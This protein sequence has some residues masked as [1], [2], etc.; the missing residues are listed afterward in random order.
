[1]AGK[2]REIQLQTVINSQ[3]LWDEML[4]NK[5]LTV[6]DVYQA[7]CGPCKA[8]Q[9]LFR[10][11]KNELNEDEILHFVV[12]EADSVA[13]LQPFRDNCEPIF[14]FSVNGKIVSKIEGANAP[15]VNKTIINLVNDEKKIAAGEIVRPQYHEIGLVGS[16]A[17]VGRSAS[18]DT[19]DRIYSIAIIKPEARN[20]GKTM[21][22]KENIVNAGFVIEAEDNRV[23][24][25]NQVREF[26][27]QIAEQ[28]DF[29]E[30][31]SLM[32]HSLSCVLVVSRSS[33][34]VP[35]LEE[36]IISKSETEPQE[37]PEGQPEM[38]PSSLVKKKWDSLEEYLVK[39]NMHQFCDV[40]EDVDNVNKLIDIFFPDFKNMKLEKTLA[41]LRPD[42]FQEKK[43][44]V[45]NIIKNE[46]FHILM[47]RP[48]VLSEEEARTLCKEYENENYFDKVIEN[49]TSLCAQFAMENLPINQLY[50]SDS[51]EAAEREIQYFFPPQNTLA[52][53]KPQA[54]HAQREMIFSRIKEAGFDI[55]Q[56]KEILLT[57]EH[58]DKIYYKIA[59]KDFYNGVLEVLS[60]GP[61]LVMILSKWNA[62]AD[63]RRLMGPTDPSEAKFLSPNSL[64]AQ[65]GINLL[66]NAVHGSSNATEAM[67]SI[68]NIF[69]EVV[70]ENPENP[71]EN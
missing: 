35:L 40:E 39:E 63:W 22:I 42:L 23:L 34:Q 51:P 25:E 5:G 14:L 36:E 48:V 28:P 8:M 56:M 69:E 43:E 12:A 66:K 4:Q 7:W 27:S 62:I 55:I 33:E 47:Q 37:P 61:S 70:P 29:E 9:T 46:G 52:V 60:E 50:G 68:N 57:K 67:Q 31:V 30:F 16:N 53:I 6:I 38:D 45:L 64:R 13:A 21:E 32:T 18:K 2:K 15:L 26:Y 19:L 3:S 11:L 24:T 1:M 71:E 54:T 65:F 17:E 58:A 20:T 41:F 59:Q 10:K 49:M 44:D